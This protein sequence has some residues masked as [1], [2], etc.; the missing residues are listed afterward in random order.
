MIKLLT[1][2]PCMHGAY[3]TTQQP[4]SPSTQPS[5]QKILI[6]NNKQQHRVRSN[7]LLMFEFE[8]EEI[9]QWAE[10]ANGDEGGRPAG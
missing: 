3:T 10:M 1:I 2:V 6:S 5:N 4:T 7:K 9:N 8:F